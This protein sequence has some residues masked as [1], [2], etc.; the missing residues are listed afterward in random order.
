MEVYLPKG[1]CGL[2]AFRHGGERASQAK[3]AYVIG[4]LAC[5]E[6]LGARAGDYPLEWPD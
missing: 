4:R 5:L 1:A 2:W 6:T 3:A